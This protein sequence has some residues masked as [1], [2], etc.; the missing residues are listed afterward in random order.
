MAA[1]I[2]LCRRRSLYV[3]YSVG[4]SSDRFGKNRLGLVRCPMILSKR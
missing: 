2:S 1:P 4:I 3:I